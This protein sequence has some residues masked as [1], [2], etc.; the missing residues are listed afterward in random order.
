M[1]T[2]INFK[3]LMA[4][5]I[6]KA[7]ELIFRQNSSMDSEGGPVGSGLL[8]VH[9]SRGNEKKNLIAKKKR[10]KESSHRITLTQIKN[11]IERLKAQSAA[12]GKKIAK[13]EE[14]MGGLDE[15][16]KKVGVKFDGTETDAEKQKKVQDTYEAILANG[17]TLDAQ[18]QEWL[19]D[20]IQQQEIDATV[21]DI[22]NEPDPVKQ[23]EMIKTAETVVQ[24]AAARFSSN[25]IVVEAAKAVVIN[26]KD[27]GDTDIVPVVAK[28]ESATSKMSAFE[29]MRAAR[30][31]M[32][33]KDIESEAMPEIRE[34]FVAAVN[35]DL[36][37]KVVEPAPVQ[38]NIDLALT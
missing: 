26:A 38:N 21:N 20:R 30:A 6:E 1:V 15:M 35:N 16:A 17:G 19:D 34:H 18:Q 32:P 4:T 27:N 31:S 22:E 23:S 5:T 33:G 37:N 14:D 2:G 36:P 7:K 28:E 12:L 3:E 29:R 25:E 9:E 10:E 8:E 24:R 11:G 13:L